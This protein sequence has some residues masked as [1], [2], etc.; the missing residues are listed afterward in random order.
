M[1]KPRKN[2]YIFDL[3]L[4]KNL[5]RPTKKGIIEYIELL[6]NFPNSYNKIG[7]TSEMYFNCLL[8]KDTENAKVLFK[9]LMLL[10]EN[11]KNNV[12]LFRK[13]RLIVLENI[14]N[15]EIN[16]GEDGVFEYY[17]PC[18]DTDNQYQKTR[19]KYLL[20][21]YYDKRK[22]YKKRDESFKYVLKYGNN[23]YLK[24]LATEYLKKK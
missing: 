3:L 13:N 20:G 18:F 7:N 16:E 21:I 22:D 5:I 24:T 12:M 23:T 8:I 14:F 15:K 11:K 10:I 2:I 6:N 17:V 4:F 9:K 1:N 19:T